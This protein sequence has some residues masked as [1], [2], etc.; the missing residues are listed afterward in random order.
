MSTPEEE[1]NGIL[2]EFSK[3]LEKILNETFIAQLKLIKEDTTKVSNKLDL[4]R[5]DTLKEMSIR[6]D[7]I[8]EEYSECS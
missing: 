3:N 1:S 7:H 8:I 5:E 2:R 6:I 4:S